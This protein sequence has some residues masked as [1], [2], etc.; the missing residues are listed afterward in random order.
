M[1]GRGQKPHVVDITL[2]DLPGLM[3]LERR[4]FDYHWNEEQYRLGLEK[5]AFRIFGIVEHG[6]PIAY[7]AFSQVVDEVE[8]LN[9][10]V[11]P[12]CRRK[13]FG[14]ALMHALLAHCRRSGIRHGFL[15]VKRSNVPA[16][17]LYTKFGFT[18]YG[19]RKCYY[20]DTKE[21]ALLFRLDFFVHDERDVG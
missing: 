6:N 18:Q 2:A 8:I 13:G 10:A 15:D 7:L 11:H 3:R 9:L 17:A 14:K 16:I 19:E 1:I 5:G 20:P 12:T 21:D 4:C